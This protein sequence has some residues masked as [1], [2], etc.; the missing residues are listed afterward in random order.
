MGAEPPFFLWQ[1]HKHRRPAG[2][3]AIINWDFRGCHME[4]KQGGTWTWVTLS[5]CWPLTVWTFQWQEPKHSLSLQFSL[6]CTEVP[7]NDKN[8]KTLVMIS[9]GK[10][11]RKAA[12]SMC[13]STHVLH[14]E[15]STTYTFKTFPVSINISHHVNNEK[16][17][18]CRVFASIED[19]LWHARELGTR[20]H[21]CFGS[22]P[23]IKVG[24][25][26]AA[27]HGN[28]EVLIS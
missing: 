25:S 7:S 11:G 16:D 2:D 14:K 6:T 17:T 21:S 1:E 26:T 18:L 24:L 28:C 27:T 5:D 13:V 15:F 20:D 23:L 3:T 10:E 19:S 9:T 22:C 8:A 4:P 12:V